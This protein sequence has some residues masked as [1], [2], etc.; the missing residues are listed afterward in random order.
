M[1]AIHRRHA[2]LPT[3]IYRA[4]LPADTHREPAT[5]REVDCPQ[6]LLG[7]KTTLNESDEM[8]AQAANDIRAGA[9]EYTEMREIEG[10]TTFIFPPGQECF[11]SFRHSQ[12]SGRP[13]ILTRDDYLHTRPQDWNE[14]MNQTFDTLRRVDERG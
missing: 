12:P 5:C 10:L 6:F 3:H 13:P 2:V 7:F 4:D 1:T 14:D 8:H 9:R 11:A